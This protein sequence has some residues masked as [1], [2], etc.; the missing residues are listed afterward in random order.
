MQ[1]ASAKTAATRVYLVAAVA[2]NGI[3][4]A[5][6]KLPWHL[7][8]DLKHFRETTLGHAVVMGRRTWLTLKGP[9]KDRQNIVLSRSGDVSNHDSV[10]VP[11]CS[12]VR[13]V[14]WSVMIL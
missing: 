8:E 2:D 13:I 5:A 11:A 9:L 6:G 4:G 12:A 3:I 10:M 1:E 14:L 7:P